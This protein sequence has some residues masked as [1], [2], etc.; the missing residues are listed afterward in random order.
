M[1][2]D[3]EV[4]EAHSGREHEISVH[5]RYE[6]DDCGQTYYDASERV[7][8]TCRCGC[9]SIVPVARVH[10]EYL[11]YMLFTGEEQTARETAA[12]LRFRADLFEAMEANGWELDE[13]KT[14]SHL[15]F[16]KD[17]R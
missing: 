2:D 5:T 15:T 8:S 6:C 11:K 14:D 16:V 3:T 7:P 12:A 10:E 9:S 1:A 4:I 17:L 13:A